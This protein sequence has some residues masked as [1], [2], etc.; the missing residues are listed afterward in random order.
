ASRSAAVEQAPPPPDLATISIVGTN[1]L[2]GHIGALPLLGGHLANLRRARAHDGAVL[3]IDGGDMFQG[4]LESNLEEGASVVRAY[5]ALGYDAVTIGNH[6]FDYGP[7]GPR[8]TP[9]AGTDD[10]RGALRAR[11]AEADYPFLSAN[12]LA[13]ETG[14]HAGVG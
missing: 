6:E 11:M 3:L 10:P 14:A 1:D 2:H 7:I 13:R 8:A 12:L 5:E 9:R 4:T